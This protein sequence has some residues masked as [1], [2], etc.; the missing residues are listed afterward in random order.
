LD[1][2]RGATAGNRPGSARSAAT[3]RRAPAAT[4]A[5]APGGVNRRDIGSQLE[6]SEFGGRRRLIRRSR[7]ER[8][9][10]NRARES[11]LGKSEP[12]RRGC[13]QVIR[14]SVHFC[15]PA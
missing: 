13:C 3:T 14:S 5:A 1:A 6:L 12:I 11:W 2:H 15:S 4:S 10:E 9:N 7:R 8:Q